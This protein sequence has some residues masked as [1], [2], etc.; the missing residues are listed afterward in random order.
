MT[1]EADELEA[2][3]RTLAAYNIA[4]D[5]MRLE[6]LAATFMAEG[7][8]E[9][10]T[11]TLS[12]RAAIAAGLGGGARRTESA[13]A[14]APPGRRRPSFVRHHLTTCLLELTG[15]ERAAGRTYFTVFTDIGPD[16]AGVYADRLCKV[17]GRWLFEHRKVMIDWLSEDTLFGN[18]VEAH[19]ARLAARDAARAV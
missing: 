4:G 8:L 12:G 14:P 18:L 9:I 19:K 1:S 5:R 11:A 10:P 6:E 17:D 15:P 7:V 13:D 3:R 2:I 16:H